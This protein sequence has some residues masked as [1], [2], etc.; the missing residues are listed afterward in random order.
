MSVLLNNPAETLAPISSKTNNPPKKKKGGG[1]GGGGVGGE[2]Q[3]RRQTVGYDSLVERRLCRDGIRRGAYRLVLL[4]HTL[5]ACDI[6]C[7][8][9]RF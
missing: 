6:I 5:R 1:G 4:H 7:F 2:Q 3:K 8:G 9:N